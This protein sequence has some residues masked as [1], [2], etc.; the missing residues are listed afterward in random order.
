MKL[1]RFLEA[2]KIAPA[3]RTVPVPQ[4]LGAV[5]GVGMVGEPEIACVMTCI[6]CGGYG[7]LH[8]YIHVTLSIFT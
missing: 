4:S 8:F 2:R 1:K 6:A 3:S 7:A 5:C